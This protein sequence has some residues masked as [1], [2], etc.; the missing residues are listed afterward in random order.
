MSLDRELGIRENQGEYRGR[1]AVHL[2]CLYWV[3]RDSYLPQGSQ[4]LKA[5][6]KAKLGM[7]YRRMNTFLTSLFFLKSCKVPCDM[8]VHVN[9]EEGKLYHTNKNLSLYTFGGVIPIF[10]KDMIL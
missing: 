9:R 10:F 1:C 8:A 3:K 6:T 4:G 7:K 5:V 2:D